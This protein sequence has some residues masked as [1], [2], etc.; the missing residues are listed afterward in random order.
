MPETVS[1]T[2]ETIHRLAPDNSALQA[3]RDLVRKGQFKGQGVSADKTWLLA[4]CQGSGKVPYELSVDLAGDNPVGRCT[5][6]SRKFPCKHCLGLML[7]YVAKPDSFAQKEPPAD[8]A[9]KRTKQAEKSEKKK[10]EGD[11]PAKVNQAAL[12]KKLA[13]QREGLDL[14]EKLVLDLVTSGQWAAPAQVA[15]LERQSKQL[16]DAYLPGARMMLNRLIL[17]AQA[18]E[19][20]EEEKQTLGAD[21]IGQLWATVQ[22]G[23]NYL[24]GK[25]AG[26]EN[27]AEA[28]AV[29]EEVLGK[30][31]QLTDLREKGYTQ[32]NLTLWELAYERYDDPAREER[33]ETSHLLELGSGKLF[34]AVA[35][36]PFKGMKYIAEQ[37]SYQTV[38]QIS[39]AAVYPGFLHR[40]IRWEKEL[41][42]SR[43]L[44]AADRGKAVQLAQP[45]FAEALAAF[46]QQ[47]KHPLAPREAAVL[48]K[49]Q[50]IG[51][52]DQRVFL[53]DAKGARLEAKDRQKNYSTV[54]NLVRAAGMVSSPTVLLRLFVQPTT[55]TIVGE[56]LAA[57]TEEV[58]LR[59]GI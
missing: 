43:P 21:L 25:L 51:L 11:K 36:R 56:P 24:D 32:Q 42:K 2:E 17:L 41:E 6:P 40:R 22:K 1:L 29:V 55:N 8:L 57:L 47:L 12:N 9:A 52:L 5:C 48:L 37:P 50:K 4:Q 19:P 20:T 38:L 27:Q 26:D 14:L 13:A 18:D 58:H 34:K 10:Q 30:A 7:L 16:T 54:A 33:I 39:D 49:C 45:G 31:W 46:R 59:L 44:E 15:R 28:D 35:Y 3:A 53:E 23:R